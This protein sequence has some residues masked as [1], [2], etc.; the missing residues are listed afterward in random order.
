MAGLYH[1]NEDFLFVEKY[2]PRTISECILPERLKKI[3]QD[4]VNKGEFGSMTFAGSAGTGKTTIAKA[5]CNELGMD[6]LVINASLERNIDTLRTQIAQ[7]AST[8]S[9]MACDQKK[10]VILDEADHLNPTSTQPALRGFI[11]EFSNNCTFILTCNFKNKIIEPLHSRAPIV[12]FAVHVN[13]KADLMVQFMNRTMEILDAENIKY[14]KPVVAEI[15]KKHFPDF[16]RILNELQ[17]YSTSGQ[18]DS[19]ILQDIGETSLDDLVSY[20]KNKDF[21]GIRKWVKDNGDSDFQML[22]RKVYDAVYNKI[23][24]PSTPELVLITADYQH[25]SAFAI[26]QELN[27]LACMVEIMSSLEFK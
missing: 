20:L 13:E 23:K 14:S 5:L 25:K 7:F 16:R 21:G 4:I 6:V 18:I 19:G 3:F 17:R 24:P 9:L 12:D 11:E 8:V 15:I 2:R 22:L 27:F 26:D 1:D 10:V